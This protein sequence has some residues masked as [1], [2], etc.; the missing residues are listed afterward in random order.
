[1]LREKVQIIMAYLQRVHSGAIPGDAETMRSMRGIIEFLSTHKSGPETDHV[2]LDDIL[3]GVMQGLQ[4][5]EEVFPLCL[6]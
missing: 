5:V 6:Q 4:R 3:I 1:M 2:L